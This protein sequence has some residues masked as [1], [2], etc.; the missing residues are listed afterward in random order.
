VRQ[1]IR[2]AGFGGQGI[3]LAGHILGR[4]AALFGGKEAVFSQSYGPEARGG[5]CAAEVV[6]STEPVDYPLFEEADIV[7]VMSLEA[8]SK[9]APTV[10]PE[11]QL[12]LDTDLVNVDLEGPNV[13][14]APFTRMAE[15]LGNRMAANVVMLGFLTAVTG[16]VSR[17]AME[18]AVRNSVRARFVDLNVKAFNQGYELVKNPEAVA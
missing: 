1:D 6:I 8:F 17:E 11:G 2:L 14:R 7:A 18:E 15:S 13:H 16:V 10:K 12:L 5:A 3:I 4:A 9:Y